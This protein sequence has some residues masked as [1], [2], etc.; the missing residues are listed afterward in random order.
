MADGDPGA[1]PDDTEPSPDVEPQQTGL[2]DQI[3]AYLQ[4][5]PADDGFASLTQ[6]VGG[7]DGL[8]ADGAYVPMGQSAHDA[9]VHAATA[10]P[11]LVVVPPGDRSP[12]QIILADHV[13]VF[14]GPLG[15][16]EP[17]APETREQPLADRI[18]DYVTLHGRVH[19]TALANVWGAEVQAAVEGDDRLDMAWSAAENNWVV[20]LVEPTASPAVTDLDL[21]RRI[22]KELLDE[23]V[24]RRWALRDLGQRVASLRKDFELLED[25]A[26]RESIARAGSYD[27]AGFLNAL[28]R[29]EAK[30]AELS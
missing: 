23:E 22:P 7:L 25:A 9:V 14:A 11:R 15:G 19:L 18:A 27:E 21:I 3:V 6:I 4:G 29:I 5:L 12:W 17:A 30:A 8:F 10:D 26:D 24:D 28:E 1:P 20:T 13:A 16:A 2:G